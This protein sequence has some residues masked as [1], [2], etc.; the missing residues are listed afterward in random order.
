MAEEF[1]KPE[2]LIQIDH[3]APSTDWMETPINIRPGMYCYASN[4]KSVETLGLPNARAWNPL[5]EDWKLP[6]NWQQIIDEQPINGI[7]KYIY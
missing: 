5:E 2:Q 3:R 4:P 7:F 1:P 6:D